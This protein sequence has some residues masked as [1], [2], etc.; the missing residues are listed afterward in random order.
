MN[1]KDFYKKLYSLEK[2]EFKTKDFYI[3]ILSLG[4]RNKED[5]PDYKNARIQI[6]GKFLFGDI[7]FHLK[8]KDWYHHFHHINPLYKNVILHIVLENDINSNFVLSSK[9]LQIPTIQIKE[10]ELFKSK[11][12]QM[13]PLKDYFKEEILIYLGKNRF[14]NRINRLKSELHFLSWNELFFKMVFRNLLYKRNK[15]IPF[16]VTYSEWEKLKESFSIKEQEF[17]FLSIY[18]F[19]PEIK[20]D[21]YAE[22]LIK[23]FSKIKIKQNRD[24]SVAYTRPYNYPPRRFA[25]MVRIFKKTPEEIYQWWKRELLKGE[26]VGKIIKKY[27]SEIENPPSYWHNHISW[28]KEMK[29]VKLVG[30]Q[31]LKNIIFNTFL[32]LFILKAE[33]EQDEKYLKILYAFVENF[34]SIEKNTKEIFVTKLFNTNFP[35]KAISQ[36]GLL[37]IYE[38]CF[39]KSQKMCDNCIKKYI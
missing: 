5:G 7:E 32:P 14:F 36:Y 17:Y 16:L 9:G 34:P 35:N 13:C 4:I 24:I 26:I 19:I 10:K 33:K 3:K 28:N 22:E 21:K 38:N 29:T 37:A 1:E 18:N 11:E 23:F 15:H 25:G 6:N 30:E 20:K 39:E 8:A 2:Q 31:R 27:S 12:I